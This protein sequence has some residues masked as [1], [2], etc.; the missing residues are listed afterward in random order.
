[1]DRT[2]T[3]LPS[4][5]IRPKPVVA[6]VAVVVVVVGVV[7]ATEVVAVATAKLVVQDY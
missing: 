2:K 6:V 4:I 7:A 5:F 3:I 1:M